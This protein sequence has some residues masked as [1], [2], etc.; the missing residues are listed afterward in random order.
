M[1]DTILAF[2]GSSRKGSWNARLLKVVCQHAESVGAGVT[3]VDLRDLGL[4]IYD[5][6]VEA[7]S[8]IPRQAI[9]FRKLLRS[10]RS[11]LIACPEYNGSVA[12]LLKNTLD[13]CSRPVDGQDGLA[14]FRGKHVAMV[15]ASLGP[16]G[17]LRALGHLRA[18]LSKMG[19][20]VLADELS[21]PFA[22]QAFSDSGML[23]DGGMGGL[24]TQV[25]VSLARVTIEHRA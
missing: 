6:D 18:I 7:E 1:K 2:S 15:S 3:T 20:I 14:P 5:G 22:H 19:A 8:G 23:V 10:H 4:P 9:E 21:I 13:W 12:P 11:M 25:G 24:A 16:F 17:G